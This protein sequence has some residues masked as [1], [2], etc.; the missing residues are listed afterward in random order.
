[1][2]NVRRLMLVAAGAAL[3]AVAVAALVAAGGRQSSGAGADP[4]STAAP[5]EQATGPVRRTRVGAGARSALIVYRGELEAE[6]PATVFLHGWGVGVRRYAPWLNHLARRGDTV[7]APRY[8]TS[9]ASPPEDV[10][11]AAAAGLRDALRGLRVPEDSLVVAGHSAGGALAADLAVLATRE[12]WLPAPVAIFSVYPGRAIL[13]TAGIPE[14]PLHSLPPDT[15]LLALAGASD[16]IVGQA[17]AQAVAQGATSLPPRNRRYHLITN[18]GVADHFGPTRRSRA[19]RH[20]F[21][22]RLDRLTARARTG[23]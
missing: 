2:V 9:P 4:A 17:P 14:L 22:Q 7:I 18:V 8:Q 12:D 19:A 15:H 23:G 10:L 20:A 16:T 1:V 13:G 11:R 6:R 3:A 21:W 5:E